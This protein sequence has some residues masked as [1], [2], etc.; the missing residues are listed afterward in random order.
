M[1]YL[2]IPAE[3][4]RLPT[5]GSALAGVRAP[6]WGGGAALRRKSGGEGEGRGRAP[7]GGGLPWWRR[8]EGLDAGALGLRMLERRQDNRSAP[9]A[10]DLE[11]DDIC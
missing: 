6:A 7:A 8:P 2:R 11:R 10:T 4:A 3:D 9:L 5:R 1:A